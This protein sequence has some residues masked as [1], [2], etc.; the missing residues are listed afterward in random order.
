MLQAIKNWYNKDKIQAA[1]TA[2]TLA[3]IEK[4]FADQEAE[5]QALEFQLTTT[6]ETLA[7]AQDE[8]SVR[9]Q[10]DEADEAKRNGVEPWVEIKS[11]SVDPV[12]GIQIELDWNEAFV[13]YLKDNGIA[14]KSDEGIVQKWVAMLYQDLM[15]K[16][17][18]RVI[19]DSDKPR[20][21]DFL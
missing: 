5:K 1:E 13:Q 8:L 7:G 20:V 9:R 15:Q 11:D 18:Q 19:D 2:A 10:Q 21:N 4:R 3:R 16:M 17:E 12:K 14:A 6:K